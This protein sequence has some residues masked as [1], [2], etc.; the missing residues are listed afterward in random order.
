[1]VQ[2]LTGSDTGI[3]VLL[4]GL[5]DKIRLL[6]QDLTEI[7]RKMDLDP[8]IG[9]AALLGRPT[10]PYSREIKPAGDDAAA[11]I[12][13]IVKHKECVCIAT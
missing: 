1:M 7:H 10:N 9:I 13:L 4:K 2:A 8:E 5:H 12:D 6:E 11:W 3:K